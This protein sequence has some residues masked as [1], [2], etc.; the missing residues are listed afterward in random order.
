MRAK[1]LNNQL[2]F[3]ENPSGADPANDPSSVLFADFF[4]RRALPAQ[5]PVAHVVS[6]EAERFTDVFER[7]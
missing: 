5:Q 6:I 7:E 3:T 4:C 1:W 2:N